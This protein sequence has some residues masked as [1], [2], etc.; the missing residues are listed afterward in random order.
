MQASQRLFTN[1]KHW[2]MAQC[3]LMGPFLI[4]LSDWLNAHYA[5]FWLRA[6][7]GVYYTAVLV[8]AGLGLA[9]LPPLRILFARSPRPGTSTP[10]PV[11][12]RGASNT[13]AGNRF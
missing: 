7:A 4:M 5:P 3:A 11:H 12:S 1:P 10:A 13:R 6:V 8:L 2:A 9:S